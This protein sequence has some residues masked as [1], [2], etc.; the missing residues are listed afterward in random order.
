MKGDQV[1]KVTMCG[2]ID[3]L[4][5]VLLSIPE[6]RQQ[7]CSCPSY[8]RCWVGTTPYTGGITAVFFNTSLRNTVLNSLSGRAGKNNYISKSM[9]IEMGRACSQNGGR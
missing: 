6:L 2:Q 7:I 9:K 5:Q 3:D 8:W 4:H 1:R